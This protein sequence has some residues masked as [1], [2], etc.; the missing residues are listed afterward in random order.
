MATLHACDG[1]DHC[2]PTLCVQ[3]FG[4][5]VLEALEA[6][7]V[8][9]PTPLAA[10]REAKAWREMLVTSQVSVVASIYGVMVSLSQ[11]KHTPC[12]NGVASF[13]WYQSCN[14]ERPVG[15]ESG[16]FLTMYW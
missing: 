16:C 9:A 5:D 10:V 3:D 8:Y 7:V 15:G 12:L 6:A 11:T 1:A 13:L 14:S 2:L 4:P